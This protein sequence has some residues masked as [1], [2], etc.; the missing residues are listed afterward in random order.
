MLENPFKPSTPAQNLAH[1]IASTLQDIEGIPYY[2]SLVQ[3]HP[4]GLLT[5]VLQDVMAVPSD[6]IRKSRGA[7]FNWYMQ[8]YTGKIKTH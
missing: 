6:K 3:K 4:A 5:K 1:E 7:L 2:L 8:R